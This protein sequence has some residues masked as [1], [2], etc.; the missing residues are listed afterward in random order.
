MNALLRSGLTRLRQWPPLVLFLIALLLLLVLGFIDYSMPPRMSF[1]LYYLLIVAFAGWAV[2]IR[3]ALLLAAASAGII[4]LQEAFLHFAPH[5]RPIVY[6]NTFT[7][8]AVF[9]GAGWLAAEATMLT[10]NLERLVQQRTLDLQAETD[11]HKATASRLRESLGVC[12]QAEQAMRDREE[13]FRIGLDAARMVVWEWDL[14]SKTIHYSANLENFIGSPEIQPYCDGD[15]VMDLIHPEDRPGLMVALERSMGSERVFEAEYRARFADGSYRWILG[16]G[17]TLVDEGGKPARILGVSLDINDRKRDE[18]LLQI[19]RDVARRLS[20]AS[21]LSVGLEDLLEVL[22]QIEGVDSGGCYLLEPD[23]GVRLIAHRALSPEFVA[24]VSYYPAETPQAV[25][26]RAGQPVYLAEPAL[27]GAHFRPMEDEGL[28]SLAM[29]PLRHE[30]SIIGAL[31]LAS[32]SRIE[33]SL[34]SRIVMEAAAAQ[35]AGAIARIRAEQLRHQL[36]RQLLTISDR[37]QAQVGQEIHDGLCQQLVSLAFDAN[38][39]ERTLAAE[40]H[41]ESAT[42]RRL[43]AFLD[44]SITEARRLSRGLF[45]IRLENEGLSSALEE[46]ACAVQARFRIV[47]HA[48]IE[49]IP[50][51]CTEVANNLF[52]IAQE[53]TTNAVKHSRARNLWISLR[54]HGNDLELR[55]EDDGVGLAAASS[56]GPGLGLHIMDYR[57]RGIGGSFSIVPRLGGGTAVSCRVPHSRL[58]AERDSPE[59]V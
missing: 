15:T 8:M 32:H 25:L 41:P 6:W 56:S 46:L 30:N 37:E 42:A 11:Q 14:E 53:A 44:E 59:S 5:E 23:G 29:I 38:T 10:R 2:G 54:C 57:A 49:L 39:L 7:R 58:A 50:T 22:T 19:Q 33:V 27:L 34:Q 1:T 20:V 12:A 55:V 45:P 31:N 26:V 35:A 9:S 17:R 4:G 21:Q 43:A 3:G 40:S 36:E 52:R 13:R 24:A 16:K 18:M 51:S 28:R 48:A 47:C